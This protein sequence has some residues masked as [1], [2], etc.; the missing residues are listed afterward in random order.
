M[1]R[2]HH[3]YAASL[4]PRWLGEEA[5]AVGASSQW[6]SVHRRQTGLPERSRKGAQRP[7]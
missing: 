4:S 6:L 5:I 7:L 1:D 3:M 2:M